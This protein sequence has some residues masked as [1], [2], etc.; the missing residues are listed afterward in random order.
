[1]V[2][3]SSEALAKLQEGDQEITTHFVPVAAMCDC[4]NSRIFLILA[5]S[6]TS[7]KIPFNILRNIFYKPLPLIW[8]LLSQMDFKTLKTNLSKTK[9]KKTT[10]KKTQP[11]CVNQKWFPFNYLFSP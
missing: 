9:N 8:Y 4:L 1:V 10:I 5:I 2:L 7:S 3:D 6:Y 11:N